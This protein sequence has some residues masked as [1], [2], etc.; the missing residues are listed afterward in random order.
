MQCVQIGPECNAGGYNSTKYFSCCLEYSSL[1]V[2]FPERPSQMNLGPARLAVPFT[3]FYLQFPS[4][5]LCRDDIRL[6][7]DINV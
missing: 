2:F 3:V 6:Y 1:M 7:R 5:C 4:S